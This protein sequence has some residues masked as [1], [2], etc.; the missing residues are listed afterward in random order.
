MRLLVTTDETVLVQRLPA[1]ITAPIKARRSLRDAVAGRVGAAELDD[2]RL[3]LSELVANSV[4][5][6]GLGPGDPIE[7]RVKLGPAAICVKVVDEGGGFAAA[8]A[9]QSPFGGRGLG[10]V[11]RLAMDWGHERD[12]AR[13]VV[14]AELPRE[15]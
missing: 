12:G 14:W 1:D 4:L 2:A 10:I 15:R 9:E 7:V 8:A 11:D 5:H 3:V 13:T 6:G